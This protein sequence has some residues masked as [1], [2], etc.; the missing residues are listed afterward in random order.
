MSFKEIIL[1]MLIIELLA[2]FS[3]ILAGLVIII[4]DLWEKF[5]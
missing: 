2:I 5:L 4:M 1:L 3:V